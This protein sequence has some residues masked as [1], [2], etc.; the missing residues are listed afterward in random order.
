MNPAVAKAEF[1][2]RVTTLGGTVLGKYIGSNAPVH[3][4]C[5]TGHDCYPIPSNIRRGQGICRLCK[6]KVW[7]VFYLMAGKYSFKLGITSGDPNGRIRDHRSNGYTKL[8]LLFAKLPGTVAK[9]LEDKLK[10]DLKVS[11][12][13]PIERNEIFV[14]D[15]LNLALYITAV[16]MTQYRSYCVTGAE[17]LWPG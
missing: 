4:R 17:L 10:R 14:N 15:A 16:E 3:V 6:G 12:Y 2:Q 5:S 7:D 11:C 1:I 13:P 8:V 9:D